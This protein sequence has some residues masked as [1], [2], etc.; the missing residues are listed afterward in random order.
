MRLKVS[1]ILGQDKGK[2]KEEMINSKKLK[3]TDLL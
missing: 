1:T 2:N 3:L